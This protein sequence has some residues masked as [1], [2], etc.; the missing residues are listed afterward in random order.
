MFF[1]QKWKS[2]QRREESG[3]T[4]TGFIAI[5]VLLVVIAMLMIVYAPSSHAVPVYSAAEHVCQTRGFDRAR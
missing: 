2:P 1:D 4:L 5:M 3:I